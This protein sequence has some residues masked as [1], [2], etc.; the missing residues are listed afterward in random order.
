MSYFTSERGKAK[1]SGSISY[2]SWALREQKNEERKDASW[3]DLQSKRDAPLVVGGEIFICAVY[4]PRWNRQ[5][6]P[7]K[8]QGKAYW[9]MQ[10]QHPT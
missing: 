9:Q 5:Y 7:N 10:L 2:P 4:H 1:D 6:G 3:H 8:V